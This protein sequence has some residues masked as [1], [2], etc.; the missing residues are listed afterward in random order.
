MAKKEAVKFTALY[1][2]LSRDDEQQGESNSIRNQKAYLEDYARKSGFSYT[3]HFTDD[4]YSGTNFNRPGIN[5]LLR[6]VEAG[7]VET[8]IV[9]DLSRFGRNYLQV[10]F[11]T[12][13]LFPDKGVRFIAINNGIDS[14]KP[15]ENDFA[16]FLNIMN[17][18]YAKDTS[19]KIRAVFKAR[20]QE[21]KRCSGS[22]PYGYMRLPGDKQTL[23]VDE[24]AAE[25]VRRIYR[26]A[27]DGKGV[28]E[29]A[30][31]L[32]SEK[33]LI[34]AAYTEKYHPEDSRHNSYHDPYS[35]S[36]HTVSGILDRREYL[37]HTVLGKSVCENFKTK[38]RRKARPDEL[39]VFENTHEAVID[40]ETWETAQRMRKRGRK[41]MPNGSYGSHRLSGM[42]YCADCGSRL[43]YSSPKSVHRA[44]GRSYDAD[45]NFRCSSYRQRYRDCTM[46]Y[47]KASVL[48]ELVRLAIQKAAVSVMEDEAGFMEQVRS[49]S[50]S[51][52]ET[53]LGERQKELHAMQKRVEE[54]DVLVRKLYE[55]NATGKIPDRYFDKLLSEYAGEQAGLERQIEEIQKEMDGMDSQKARADRFVALVKKYSDYSEIT[56]TMLNEF[57]EK[58]VVHEAD[59]STGDRIQK[60]DIY[61]NFI[62]KLPEPEESMTEGQREKEKKALAARNREREWNRLRMRRVR[63]KQKAERAL[64][65]QEKEA[66]AV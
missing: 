16:P 32:T 15:C 39:L 49:L 20:M 38:K 65:E 3:R 44:D 42:V 47:I 53:G 29:I 58:I 27:I 61:F 43:S 62:G 46:H 56:T 21:G 25:V 33:V 13:V 30:G 7:Q 18:W 40:E 59:K 34:P 24:N 23:V 4:G 5:E 54:L 28:T 51:R 6:A 45:S 41:A 63:A 11:Y 10:G 36:P 66:A 37:G 14:A 48:E 57:V 26:M 9:K 60:V 17:E 64:E 1:E 19:N 8:V 31:I 35:W 50:E 22:I 12:E 55:G 52:I 2:R